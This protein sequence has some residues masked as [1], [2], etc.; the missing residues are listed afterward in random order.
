M[1]ISSATVVNACTSMHTS[2]GLQTIQLPDMTHEVSS[3]V[4]CI[5]MQYIAPNASSA[6]LTVTNSSAV[7]PGNQFDLCIAVSPLRLFS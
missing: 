5:L 6:V 3:G 2:I 1:V 7:C 4:S